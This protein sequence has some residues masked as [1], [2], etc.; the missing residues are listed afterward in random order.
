[1]K[2]K[3]FWATSA[4]L[5]SFLCSVGAAFFVSN[6]VQSSCVTITAA[7]VFGVALFNWG[8]Q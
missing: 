7:I 8:K 2:P 4:S 5:S 6:P 3:L 1:M